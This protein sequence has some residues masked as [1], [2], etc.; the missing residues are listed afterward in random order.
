MLF[1]STVFPGTNVKWFYTTSDAAVDDDDWVAYNP[2]INTDLG[3][4]ISQIKLRIDITAMGG[5]YEIIEKH[6]GIKLLYHDASANYI[7]RNEYFTDALNYPNKISMTADIDADSINSGSGTLTQFMATIDDGVRWFTVPLKEGYSAVAAGDPYY[8]YQAETPDEATITEVTGNGVS[9]IVVTSVNHGYT[10]NMAVLIAG[11]G[12][13]TAANGTYIAT[14]VTSD[15]FE[16]Y[17]TDGTATTGDGAYTTG[18]TINL[19]EFS[20]I[21]PRI[22]LATDSRARTPR[23]RNIGCIASAI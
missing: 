16:L 13:N 6:V 4:V 1:R 11:V 12:G 2:Y 3:D 22:R 23:V 15:T 14:N 20:Q 17:T 19:A 5:S 10:E 21:R 9:P 18:G 8:R 7:G